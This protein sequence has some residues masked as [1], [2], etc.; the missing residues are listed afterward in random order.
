M[1]TWD[2]DLMAVV[3]VVGCVAFVAWMAFGPN[4]VTPHWHWL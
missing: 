3:A 4:F 1:K 2:L